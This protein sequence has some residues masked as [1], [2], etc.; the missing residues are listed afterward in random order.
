MPFPAEQQ[1]PIQISMA[2]DNANQASI[3][4]VKSQPRFDNA[5]YLATELDKQGKF[6]EA[7]KIY[8]ELLNADFGNCVLQAALGMNFASTE[9]NGLGALLLKSALDNLDALVD[10]FKRLGV[11]PKTTSNEKMEEFRLNKKAEILNALG[12]C[13]KHENKT[14][15]ARE[16]FFEA[17][18]QIPLNA[19]IQ[20]NLG[21]L[22]INE[23]LPTKALEH[24]DIAIGLQPGHPQACW[25]KSLAH[26]ELGDYKKG[27]SHYDAGFAAKVRAERNYSNTQLP[28]WNGEPG[29][30]VVVYGEQG[31]GDE[32]M[33]ASCLPDL[34]ACSKQVVFDCHKKLHVL[35]SDSFPEIDIYPTR[36]DEM[37]TWPVKGDG[38]PR[39]Q[40]DSRIAIGSLQRFFRLDLASFP[41]TPYISP[42]E[43]KKLEWAVRLNNL[44]RKPKIGISWIGGHK[45]TRVEVRSTTL[46]SLLPI[47]KQDAEFISLQYTPCEQEIAQ[48]EKKHGIKIHQ[49]PEAA[50]SPNYAETAALVANLDLVITVC[51]SLVHL[52]GSM[53]VPT[54]VLTP[55]RPAWRYRLDL[56]YMPWYGKTVTLFR[57]NPDNTTDWTPVVAEVSERVQDLLRA[58]NGNGPNSAND[59]SQGAQEIAP[60]Q[61]TQAS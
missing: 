12:T 36:E 15:E 51:T 11:T 54:W 26:L 52:A 50:Y 40:F 44:G 2:L 31:I 6:K 42:N 14:D 21:T 47:L 37:V 3:L 13:Y 48:F 16:L 8:N 43:A 29:K 34:I 4:G 58:A 61:A 23:G 32:I 30:T 49:F 45:R 55:S 59:S 33:F 25:N 20:N 19:D 17:Q 53:G 41:G 10:S 57:Q 28:Q 35:F 5:F 18:S 38:T 56:D 9:K 24:L 39:Y 46:E 60:S 22:Y 7:E 1:P 27:W